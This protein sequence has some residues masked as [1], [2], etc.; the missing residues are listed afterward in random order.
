MFSCNDSLRS[1][2]P[3]FF[4]FE[5]DFRELSLV[6]PT[7]LEVTFWVFLSAGWDNLLLPLLSVALVVLAPTPFGLDSEEDLPLDW[8][9]E[10][11]LFT[12][13]LTMIFSVCDI[14]HS[15]RAK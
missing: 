14:L 3:D 10:T 12:F 7:V 2:G 13:D 5:L 1:F 8:D 6:L 15:L 9:S 11:D 4:V